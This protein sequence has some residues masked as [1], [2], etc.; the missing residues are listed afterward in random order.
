MNQPKKKGGLLSR[1]Y[2]LALGGIAVVAV[3][4]FLGVQVLM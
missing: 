4:V 3:V 1:F 2:L